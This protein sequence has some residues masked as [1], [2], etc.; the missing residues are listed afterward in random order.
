M[1]SI[2]E[3]Q[4]PQNKAFSHQNK[5]YLGSRYIYIYRDCLMVFSAQS[6]FLFFS[7]VKKRP[8]GGIL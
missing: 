1:T 3:G 7:S 2:F 4:P 5:G 8:P 6:C